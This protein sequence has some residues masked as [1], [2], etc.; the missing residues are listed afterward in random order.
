MSNQW[1]FTHYG[2]KTIGV[3]EG[4]SGARF[5]MRPNAGGVEELREDAAAICD[6]YNARAELERKLAAY[7]KVV[8]AAIELVRSVD[9]EFQDCISVDADEYVKLYDAVASLE[10]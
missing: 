7:E 5:F 10:D 9:H 2:P 8:E 1:I 4:G 3:G 6:A